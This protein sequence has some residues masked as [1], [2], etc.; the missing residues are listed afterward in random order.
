MQATGASR[1]AHSPGPTQGWIYPRPKAAKETAWSPMDMPQSPID[2]I[3]NQERIRREILHKSDLIPA[4]PEV[5]SEVLRLLNDKGAEISDFESVLRN[6]TA[7]VAKMLRVVN[8]PFY[9]MMRQITSIQEAVMVLGFRSLRSLVLAASTANYMERNFGVY[10]H[11]RQG[12]WLHALAV[13]SGARRLACERRLPADDREEVFVAGLLHDIGKMLLAPYLR[14]KDI[15][16]PTL[17]GSVTD[18]EKSVLGIDHAEAG[19]IV[20]QR[21]NLSSTIERIIALHETSEKVEAGLDRKLACVRLADAFSRKL[22][23]GFKKNEV[24]PPMITEG[25]FEALSINEDDWE[26]LNFEMKEAIDSAISS[27]GNLGS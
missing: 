15:S 10:G 4:L 21:W 7:L 12:L 8:S 20:A 3:A 25:D 26:D 1:S 6:D 17:P 19:A 13:A 22:G 14:E 2:L 24:P 27:L 18:N 11:N 5:V 16:L 9:G 23:I